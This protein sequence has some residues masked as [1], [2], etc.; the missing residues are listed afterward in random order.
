M[1][2]QTVIELSEEEKSKASDL[3]REM[4][5]AKISLADADSRV[6]AAESARNEARARLSKAAEDYFRQLKVFA[7]GHQI[8]LKD[9]TSKWTF[10]MSKMAFIKQ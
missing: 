4:V 8:D 3:Q 1:T 9:S 6:V 5:N 10:D 2:D 7:E